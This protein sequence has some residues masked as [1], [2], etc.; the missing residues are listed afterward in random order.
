MFT[1]VGA[2]TGIGG[3]ETAN[4]LAKRGSLHP[5]TEP[6]L[7]CGISERVARQ[8]IRDWMCREH[9]QYWQ[10]IPGQRG[11]KSFPSKLSNKRTV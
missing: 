2:R 4:Q 5:F 1:A 3:N 6:E 11:T 7:A 8:V 10:S 9:Q